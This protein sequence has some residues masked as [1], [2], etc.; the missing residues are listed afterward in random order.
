MF[1]ADVYL[2]LDA[3]RAVDEDEELRLDDK[4]K[5]WFEEM[6]A[7]RDANNQIIERVSG[8]GGDGTLRL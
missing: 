3:A 2:E 5:L 4:H 6:V 1:D 8:G 7:G